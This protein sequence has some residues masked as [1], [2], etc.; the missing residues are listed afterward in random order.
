MEDRTYIIQLGGF[1]LP[2]ILGKEQSFSLSHSQ[3]LKAMVQWVQVELK[4]RGGEKNFVKN[5][6][7]NYMYVCETKVRVNG[8]SVDSVPTCSQ[9]S[10]LS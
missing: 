3:H 4:E 10:L 2:D 6:Q 9:F 7:V 8:D 1:W 5:S